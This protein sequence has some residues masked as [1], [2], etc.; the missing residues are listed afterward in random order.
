MG[1]A[2]RYRPIY[3][4]DENDDVNIYSRAIKLA[5]PL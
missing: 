5:T 4:K 3:K 2:V 1:T